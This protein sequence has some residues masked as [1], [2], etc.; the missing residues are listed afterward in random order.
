[1]Y[2]GA[3]EVA[4][5]SKAT[6]EVTSESK[7]TS[8]VATEGKATSEVATK[9][10]ATSLE[11]KDEEGNKLKHRYLIVVGSFK[12]KLNAR[13]LA[14]QLIQKGEGAP[15]IA[16]SPEGMYRVI[17][18]SSN[19]ESEIRSTLETVKRSYPSAWFL[20]IGN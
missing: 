11:Y 14:D 4:T 6:S 13:N 15:Y 17:Y 20:N 1:M 12:D 3:S 8:K 2:M 16:I 19:S 10:K 18:I 9:S 7:A 5:E